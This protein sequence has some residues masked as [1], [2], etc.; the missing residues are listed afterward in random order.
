MGM[1]GGFIA[2]GGFFALRSVANYCLNNSGKSEY[3]AKNT[4]S[5]SSVSSKSVSTTQAQCPADPKIDSFFS[6][7]S[8]SGL[9]YA[10]PTTEN[11]N[12]I[13]RKFRVHVGGEKDTSCSVM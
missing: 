1:S 11:L 3:G 6:D 5:E 9:L 12:E 8:R 10:R 13:G 4:A 7:V 2:M